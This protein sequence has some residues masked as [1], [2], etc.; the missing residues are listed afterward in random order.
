M[1]N[2]YL[3]MWWTIGV[4]GC[5]EP[6][7]LWDV[8]V[9][10]YCG[11]WCTIGVVYVVDHWYWECVRPLVLG[12]CWTIGIRNVLD[13]WY[14]EFV[15]PSIGNVGIGKSSEPLVFGIV[16]DICIRG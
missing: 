9:N 8:V 13:H 11:M 16:G 6:L 5:W 12:M 7:V 15:G 2:W 10:E 14:W 1:D 4:G 3:G